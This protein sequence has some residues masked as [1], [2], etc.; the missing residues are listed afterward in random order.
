MREVIRINT[1]RQLELKD[2]TSQVAQVVA[3][4]G[5]KQGLCTLF[6]PHTT[7]A[8]TINENADPDVRRDLERA[9]E[10]VVPSVRFDHVEGN[11]SAHFLSSMVGVSLRLLVEHACL[12]LGRW[13]AVYFCEFDGPRS[14]EVWVH[15][16]AEEK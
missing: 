1:A 16:S 13:Q 7:A 12:R 15:L 5:V 6:C 8:L 11:S 14:R 3:K 2:I 10:A 9:F 4:S